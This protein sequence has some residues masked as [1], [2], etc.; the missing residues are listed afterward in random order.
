[1]SK[2]PSSL[3]FSYGCFDKLNDHFNL[4]AGLVIMAELAEVKPPIVPSHQKIG[5]PPLGEQAWLHY[6][7][8]KKLK[9]PVE[10]GISPILL[11]VVVVTLLSSLLYT[12]EP[13]TLAVGERNRERRLEAT[14]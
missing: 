5:L 3:A 11:H 1:L 12:P 13:P 7:R 8:L 4:V 14:R 9:K 2:P 6:F 10:V